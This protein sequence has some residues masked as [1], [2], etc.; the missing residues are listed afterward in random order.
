MAERIKKNWEINLVLFIGLVLA[1]V[2]VVSLFGMKPST[3]NA[4]AAATSVTVT[5]TVSEWLSITGSTTSVAILPAL[6]DTSGNL[7]TGT[8]QIVTLTCGTNHDDGFSLTVKSD[9]AA[10][11]YNATSIASHASGS[12]TIEIGTDGYGVQ[13]SSSDATIDPIYNYWDNEPLQIVGTASTTAQ[14][15]ATNGV[16]ES[17]QIIDV[18]FKATTSNQ[19]TAGTYTDTIDF[20]LLPAS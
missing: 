16:P 6:V 18:R 20:T 7:A 3:N 9:N 19:K 15:L 8:S 13:A 5:A 17:G 12:T 1:I 2:G 10:L 14:T 11:I 4:L